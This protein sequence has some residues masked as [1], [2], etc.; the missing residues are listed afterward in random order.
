[1]NLFFKTLFAYAKYFFSVWNEPKRYNQLYSLIDQIHPKNIMEIGTWRGERAKSM[2]I[3]AQKYSPSQNIFYYGFDLFEDISPA[4]LNEEIS[5]QPPAME[6]VKND[7]N[8]TGANIA[9]YKGNTKKVFPEVIS[10]LPKMDFIFIDGGHSLET[11]QNDWDYA[12]RL[13]HSGTVV[14][15]D[16]Y[17][18]DRQDAGAKPIVDAIN[19]YLYEV[20][21]LPT[22]DVFINSGR[23][24]LIIK[25]AQVQKYDQFN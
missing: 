23:K 4:I 14:I 24:R 18:P 7:L 12:S 5:K 22:Y 2:I 19:K 16:D 15:F 8:K 17:W 21:V 3:R 6:K 10:S 9:L 20:K 25:F 1:M 13:I 11:I